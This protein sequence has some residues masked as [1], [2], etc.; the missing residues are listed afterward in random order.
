M[1]HYYGN[2]DVSGLK[3]LERLERLMGTYGF[4]TKDVD[5]ADHT[6]SAASVAG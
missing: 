2:G 4:I 6:V 5:W 3:R 1:A